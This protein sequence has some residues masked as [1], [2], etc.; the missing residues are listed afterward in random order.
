MQI[1]FKDKRV[2]VAG[3]S[4]GIGRS[5]ALGFAGAGAAVSICARGQAGLDATAGEIKALGARVHAA[6]CDLADKESI[7]A[8]VSAAAASL[9]GVDI[10]VNNASGFGGGDTEDGWRKGFDVDVMATVRASNAAIPHLERSGGG[11][12]LNISS[13]SGLGASARSSSYAAVKAAVINYTLS[14]G[15]MLAPKK[16]RVNAIAPGSIEFPGG[17]WE[18]HKTSNPQLYNAVF[19]SIPWGRL[20]KPEEIASAALFLCSDHASWITGQTL[21]V[22]GGQSLG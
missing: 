12:I 5:I 13:I 3:G 17:M 8:Y 4:R 20:G 22:D 10:L 7:A 21:T 9:G 2:V 19:K 15:L 11:A 6:P 14:Q 18:T 1:S 16:I